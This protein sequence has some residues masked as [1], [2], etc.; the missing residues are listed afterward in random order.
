MYVCERD[1]ESEE[2]E[3]NERIMEVNRADSERVRERERC[4]YI[5][6][7]AIYNIIK[8][9]GIQSIGCHFLSESVTTLILG[10]YCYFEVL[11]GFL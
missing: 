7:W 4:V 10:L 8:K 9:C 11:F 2:E 6:C 5:C 1:R 3:L